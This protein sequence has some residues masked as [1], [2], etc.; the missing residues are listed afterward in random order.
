[1]STS[2]K[3]LAG[4]VVRV[5]INPKDCMAAIDVV[6]Q[7]RMRQPAMSFSQ[8]ISIAFSCAM[9]VLR[10]N[11]I[12][13]V[14]EGFEY[15]EMMR[16]FPDNHI[17]RGKVHFANQQTITKQGQSIVYPT[18]DLQP[19]PEADEFLLDPST[20]ANPEVRR[21]YSQLVEMDA[22]KQIDPLNFDEQLY[23]QLEQ[24]LGKLL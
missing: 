2:K 21:L 1:M 3:M 13:N 4:R 6:N 22:K 11:N 18:Q 8:V 14:R 10:K 24:E 5:R 15:A 17:G 20:H 9:E 7:A 19:P 23:S 12:I 16:D